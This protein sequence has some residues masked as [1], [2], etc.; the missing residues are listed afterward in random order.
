MGKKLG[1]IF[2]EDISYSSGVNS[3]IKNKNNLSMVFRNQ[4]SLDDYCLDRKII[5]DII[6]VDV[7][8][9]EYNVLLGSK[10]IIEKFKPI[11]ILSVHPKQLLS[12]NASKEML[13][14]LINSLDVF[15]L[16]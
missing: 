11:F 10:K 5:P 15:Y 9:N 13:F 12:F 7:E 6:K 8:G 3:L 14:K 2:Y 1:V 16:S 4:V